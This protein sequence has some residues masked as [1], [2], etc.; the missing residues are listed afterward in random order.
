MEEGGQEPDAATLRLASARRRLQAFLREIETLETSEFPHTDPEDALA[1]IKAGFQK[2]LN[3][4]PR[5]ASIAL[6]NEICAKTSLAV[7]DYTSILGFILRSTN[8]RNAF[9]LYFPLKRLV[10]DVIR[11]NA[12]L[13]ISSEWD[14]IPFTY[15]M[16]LD[17]LPGYVLVGGPAPE[18]GGA[19]TTPLAGHEIAHSAWR[20]HRV[21]RSIRRRLV[22]AII[23]A[24]KTF[25]AE[26]ARLENE[27]GPE[28]EQ[29]CRDVGIKQ[30]EEIF[31]DAFGLFVFGQS[32]AFAFEHLM[33]PGG[34]DRALT[35]PSDEDRIRFLRLAA[36][37]FKIKLG[38]GF[39]TDWLPSAA[40]P[41]DLEV[42]V[43]TI[44][45]HAVDQLAPHIFDAARKILDRVKVAPPKAANVK[46]I[47]GCFNREM[48]DEDG[49]TLAEIVTAGWLSLKARGGLSFADEK[50]RF[51]TLNEVMLKSVEVS[52]YLLR[53]RDVKL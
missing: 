53:T 30:L 8:V 22:A 20:R 40:L 10:E 7:E 11:D 16:N 47:I 38:K 14:F 44:V 21:A 25:P 3:C 32:Y 28:V 24:L 9:E 43:T 1:D 52:E 18:S 37:R 41:Y 31:C 13:L 12:K 26:K 29:V 46:R 19:F 39:F 50:E 51:S 48:P 2:R 5:T 45:D 15:P 23:R 35:Y 27:L 36:T 6:V 34:A 17:L 4:L 33:A 42:D 49:G